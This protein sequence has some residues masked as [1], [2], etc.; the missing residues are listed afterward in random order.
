M[1]RSQS[2]DANE[3]ESGVGGALAEPLLL[4]GGP[5]V[6]PHVPPHPSAPSAPS[7]AAPL[8]FKPQRASITAAGVN[9]VRSVG[10]NIM[11]NMAQSPHYSSTTHDLLIGTPTRP[12]F[13]QLSQGYGTSAGQGAP[14]SVRDDHLRV[15]PPS[16]HRRLGPCA[17]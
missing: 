6:A 16:A 17:C 5:G 2:A 3:V 9:I 1:I 12:G 10:R 8:E 13:N 14:P 7:S 15:M 11:H 4:P